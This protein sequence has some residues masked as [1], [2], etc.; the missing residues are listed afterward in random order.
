MKRFYEKED[1]PVEDLAKASISLFGD[2]RMVD[3]PLD[4]EVARD[5]IEYQI[6]WN[7]EDSVAEHEKDYWLEK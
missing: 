2:F 5:A 6:F 7:G 3:E 1:C 4:P